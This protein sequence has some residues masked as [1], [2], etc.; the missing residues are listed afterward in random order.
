VRDLIAH[1]NLAGDRGHVDDMMSLF[2]PD[3]VLTIDGVVHTGHDEIR[4]LLADAKSPHPELIRHFTGTLQIEVPSPEHAAARCYF[5][6][7]TLHGLDHWGRYSDA[8]RC[9]S[10]HWLFTS[11]SVRVDG[12]TPGGWAAQRGYGGRH[13]A[14]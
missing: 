8:F 11:R 4:A 9:I 3:A 1:Y 5:E 10:D 13:D 7:L 6:V 2:A 14:P 12:A